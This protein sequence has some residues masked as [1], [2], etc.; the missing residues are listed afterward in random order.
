MSYEN[1]ALD[2]L[3]ADYFDSAYVEDG[4]FYNSAE[5][6]WDDE[7]LKVLFVLKQPSSSELLGEDYRSYDFDT[8]M[9]NIVWQE[10]LTRLYG[11]MNT[12]EYGYPDYEEASDWD[13]M[14]ETFYNYPFAVI[15]IIKDEC[16]PTTS[17]SYLKRYA[18]NNEEFLT[19]QLN[20]LRPDIIVCCGHNVFDIVNSAYSS[21]ES[22]NNYL[23]YDSDLNV[24]Y[25]DTCHPCQRGGYTAL[26]N[27]YDCMLSEYSDFLEN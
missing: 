3:C 11:I 25:F 5:E 12:D 26:E 24:I 27:A 21:I 15:N 4:I 10:L 8:L 2:E 14:R 18:R 13:N 19:N 1:E 17:S 6:D 20:I 7:H 9:E 16:S 23:K 22:D